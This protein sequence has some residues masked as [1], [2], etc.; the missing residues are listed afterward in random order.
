[1]CFDLEQDD[2]GKLSVQFGDLESGEFRLFLNWA[3]V[4]KQNLFEY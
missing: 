2:N 1:M 3:I 4:P